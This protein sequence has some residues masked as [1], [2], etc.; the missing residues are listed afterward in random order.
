MTD[1]M[2]TPSEWTELELLPRLIASDGKAWREFHRRYDRLIY[3]CI[4]KVTARFRSVIADDDVEEIFA[5]F[6]VRIASNSFRKLHQYCPERGT[7]LSTW[8]GMIATNTA[9]DHLRSVSRR[10]QCT[11]LTEVPEQACASSSPFERLVAR[12]TWTAVRSAM[13]EFSSKDQ[14]FM[15]LYYVDGLS[16]EEVAADMNVSVKT[17]YSKKHKIRT[18]LRAQLHA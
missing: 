6:L 2:L 13:S 17:V 8:L 10:P 12:E 9:W 14:R 15:E 3:R 4:H 11:E 16:P 5:Q 18:R 1:R 7:K